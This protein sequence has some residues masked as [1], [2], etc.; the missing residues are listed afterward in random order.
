MRLDCWSI[1]SFLHLNSNILFPHI[2]NMIHC[3]TWS[4]SCKQRSCCSK[5]LHCDYEKNYEINDLYSTH[6]IL[7]VS[8]NIIQIQITHKFHTSFNNTHF[9][10][11]LRVCLWVLILCKH[12]LQLHYPSGIYFKSIHSKW[13]SFGQ[14]SQQITFPISLQMSHY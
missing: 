14:V 3:K 11:L 10:P 1:L 4:P 13:K 12:S 9:L 5:E 8:I 2:F 7:H 6:A